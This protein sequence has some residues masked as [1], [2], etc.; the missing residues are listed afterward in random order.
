MLRPTGPVPTEIDPQSI[1]L[2]GVLRRRVAGDPLWGLALD[3]PSA[4]TRIIPRNFPVA[5]AVKALRPG[6]GSLRPA[7]VEMGA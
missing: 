7:G 4:T 2:P 5:S 1:G 6:G 3:V